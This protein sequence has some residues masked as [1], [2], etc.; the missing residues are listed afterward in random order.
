MDFMPDL[1]YNRERLR[2][3]LFS[4]AEVCVMSVFKKAAAFLTAVGTAVSCAACGYNTIN[5]LTVDGM[6]VPAGIYIYYAYS[7]Y[8]NDALPQL[9]KE[10]EDLDTSD[11]NA[12]KALTLDGKDVITWVQDKATE[13]CAEYAVI[14]KKFEELGLSFD[15]TTQSNLQMMQEY[16]WSNSKEMMEKNGISEASFKKIVASSYKSDEIFK[17]YYSIGGEN[18]TTEDD[19]YDYYKENSIRAEYIS[20]SLKDGEG[21]LLKS[22]GKKEIMDMGIHIIDCLYGA[23]DRCTLIKTGKLV[24]FHLIS[25]IRFSS[26]EPVFVH[27]MKNRI[28]NQCFDAKF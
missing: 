15:D 17:Y 25:S 2:I 7:A 6:E 12:V 14:E 18:G 24:F 16:Y 27:I 3:K 23:A 22:D 19:V 5:A 10:H 28:K 9:Q 4:L 20:M 13:Q 26:F 8:N 11:K 21:N 1:L